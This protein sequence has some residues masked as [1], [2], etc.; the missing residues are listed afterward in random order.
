MFFLHWEPFN[1]LSDKDELWH[2]Q[3]KQFELPYEMDGGSAA[4]D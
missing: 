1:L 3:F 2:I 4:A